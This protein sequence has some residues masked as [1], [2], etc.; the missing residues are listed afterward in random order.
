M[1]ADRR[2]VQ[3]QQPLRLVVDE[4]DAA[5][6]VGRDHALPD[7][8]QDRLALLE[9]PPISFGSRP[10]VCRLIRRASRSDPIAPSA[11]P[12]AGGMSS[13]GRSCRSCSRTASSRI[14]TETSPTMRPPSR[15]GTFAR[16][17]RPSEPVCTPTYSRP[18]SGSLGSVETRLRILAGSGCE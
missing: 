4:D 7:P 3:V 12:S 17:E 1:P 5:V 2:V 18:D 8:V 11:S 6:P 14:P 15:I 16:T 13:T 9:Q 10:N